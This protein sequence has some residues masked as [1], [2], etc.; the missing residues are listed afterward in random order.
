MSSNLCVRCGKARIV[1][2]KWKENIGNSVVYFTNNVCPD[3]ECQKIVEAK[4]TDRQ[5]RLDAIHADSLKRREENKWK[6]KN[7]KK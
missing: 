6:R 5:D 1:S 3:P 7:T 2:K 4:L